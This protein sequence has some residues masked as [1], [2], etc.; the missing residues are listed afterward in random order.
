[1]IWRFLPVGAMA[2][3]LGCAPVAE[4]TGWD[5]GDR[6]A[7]GYDEFFGGFGRTGV[8]NLW[9]ANEDA[10]LSEAEWE[11]G[12]G[13]R[14]GVYDV[15]RWGMYRD[16]DRD[17]S[18]SLSDVEFSSGVFDSYDLDGDAVLL[19]DEREAYERDWM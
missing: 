12:F 16:W 11:A 3:L 10:F 6:D 9:D 4:T 13:D 7:M 15:N 19:G 8:Y 2:L 18:G 5:V 14:F 1:M 17:R